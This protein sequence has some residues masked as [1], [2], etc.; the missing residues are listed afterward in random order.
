MDNLAVMYD[1]IRTRIF[2]LLKEQN[3]SQK[4]FAE[5]LHTPAQT[6]TDWKKGKSNS[7]VRNLSPIADI[8]HTTTS[9]LFFG[10]GIKYVPDEQREEIL[11][12]E[13]E[14][15]RA[16]LIRTELNMA[17]ERIPDDN[18]NEFIVHLFE[19]LMQISNEDLDLLEGIM[20]VMIARKERNQNEKQKPHS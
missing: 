8:L 5:M 15:S 3:I 9:W 16:G 18:L 6:I 2:D 17:I 19:M 4:E 7:F 13:R 20:R 12:H 14:K 1:E 10:E 11:Q